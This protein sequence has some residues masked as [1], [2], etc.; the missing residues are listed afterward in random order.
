MSEYANN[1]PTTDKVFTPMGPSE[2]PSPIADILVPSPY[3]E[4]DPAR[5][6]DDLINAMQPQ[7]E[8]LMAFL[9]A[10][11]QPL[12]MQGVKDL[13]DQIWEYHPIVYTAYDLC[14]LLEEAGAIERVTA[15]GQPY[16]MTGVEPIIVTDEKTGA[17]YYQANEPADMYWVLLEP[18]K[19]ILDDNDP[20][21][22]AQGY[23]E[24]DEKLQPL[25]KR[26]LTLCKEERDIEELN[27]AINFDPLAFDPRIYAPFL[28]DRMER[29]EAIEWK[30][31]WKITEVGLQAL[32]L[33]AGVEDHYDPAEQAAN[34]ENFIKETFES[35]EPEETVVFEGELVDQAAIK[36]ASK[37]ADS[38]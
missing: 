33:L 32:E 20:L 9:R 8:Y 34:K 38:E 4:D 16:S 28:V 14:V 24:A 12:S 13:Y 36:A 31:T 21:S 18:G 37:L 6:V 25:F 2:I 22:R 11:E 27:D 15:D 35:D 30:G 1:L 26:L 23:F 3:A 10:C 19:T 7:R 29:A 17:T 5:P